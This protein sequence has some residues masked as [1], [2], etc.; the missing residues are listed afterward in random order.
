MSGFRKR[1]MRLSLGGFTLVELLVVVVIIAAATLAVAPAVTSV[2][3]SNNESGAANRVSSALA[4]ARALAIENNRV[5]GV[6]FRFDPVEERS[7]LLLIEATERVGWLVNPADFAGGPA[8]ENPRAVVFRPVP[9]AAEIELPPSTVVAG[10]SVAV[11]GAGEVEPGELG[12]L[13]PSGVAGTDLTPFSLPPLDTA[14]WYSGMFAEAA[15]DTNTADELFWIFPR[16]DAR[17]YLSV[18]ELNTINDEPGETF[19]TLGG[20]SMLAEAR[21]SAAA[22][23]AMTF[24]LLFS[25]DG[26]PVRRITRSADVL[27]TFY[28]EYDDAPLNLLSGDELALDNDSAFDPEHMFVRAGTTTET[29]PNDEFVCRAVLQVAVLEL[30]RLRG[31]TGIERPWLLTSELNELASPGGLTTGWRFEADDSRLR[32]LSRW[33]DNNALLLGVNPVS[34][35]VV[36]RSEP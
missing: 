6:A 24:V 28:V 3:A 11:T 17:I 35:Q 19:W 15:L 13:N 23:H 16:D 9:G 31:G 36:R 5:T 34:G 7:R 8:V 10:L 4:N 29:T 18:D 2:L 26:T 12:V 22:R 33:I 14:Y 30:S 20:D 27:D 1:P 25:A 32:E 21:L